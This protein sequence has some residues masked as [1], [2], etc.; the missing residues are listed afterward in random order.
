[1]ISPQDISKARTYPIIVLEQMFSHQLRHR[2]YDFIGIVTGLVLILIVASYLLVRLKVISGTAVAVIAKVLPGMLGFLSILVG[3]WLIVFL[4]EAFFRSF[5]FKETELREL[6]TDQILHEVDALSFQ[7]GRIM[8]LACSYN[9]DITRAFFS[10]EMGKRVLLR[11]GIGRDDREY[12]LAERKG[13]GLVSLDIPLAEQ[14]TLFSLPKFA[15]YIMEHDEEVREFLF[16]RGIK[17]KE[18]EGAAEWVRHENE[19]NK[20]S[21]QW[22]NRDHLASIPGLGKDWAYGR[23]YKL[24]A[25]AREVSGAAF[26]EI[27]RMQFIQREKEVGELERV[28]LR[29]AEANALLVGEAGTGKMEVVGLLAHRIHSRIAPPDLEFKQI[30]ILDTARLL[31]EAG[32]KAV[33]EGELI[34]IFED[35]VHAGNIILVLKDFPDFITGARTMGSDVISVID[36]Y[37]TSPV[38]QIIATSDT[39]AFHQ[40]LEQDAGFMQRFEKITVEEADYATTIMVLERIAHEY[41]RH[42][43]IF[44]TYPAIIEVASAADQY[45]TSGVMPAK[46]VDLLIEVVPLVLSKKHFFVVKEDVHELV[47]K[48]TNIPVGEIQAEERDRLSRLEEFLHKRV[49]GQD[50]AVRAIANTMRR[51]R[52]G[53]RQ[54]QRPIGSFLFLGPTGVGKT[55]TAKALAEVFFG[56]AEHMVRLDMSEYQSAD[57]LQRLIGSFETGS[58]GTLSTMLREHPYCVL[59]LDEFEKTN[60]DVHDL[61]LQILDEGHFADMHGK[62]INARNAIIIATSNAGS[63]LIWDMVK[64]GKDVSKYSEQ[65]IEELVSEHTFKPELLNRFDGVITFHPLSNEHLMRIARLL[66]EQLRGRLLEHNNIDLEVTDALVQYVALQGYNQ[67]FGARP[68]RRFIQEHVEQKIAEQLIAGNI[69]EG[70]H[71]S[72]DERAFA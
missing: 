25:Y 10:S 37:L 52:T 9:N 34:T 19:A 31:A 24:E 22:W 45:M 68:M 35:A 16:S 66:L 43:N 46:A 71:I 58:A 41:E 64:Q 29:A 7:V 70:S 67:S 18:I 12:F 51:A 1:M 40:T 49:I 4:L 69:H 50:Q 28:L 6:T 8:Y 44:F 30:M 14:N 36:P 63:D 59:L 57:A 13:A 11:L 15:V 17:E 23:A 21:E 42:N 53:V 33:L 72:Y 38:V 26:N 60:P 47:R 54:G 20:Q 3:V 48:K 32:K 27:Y 55:E 61:F 65:F 62:R 56:S 2:I 5:Y 39:E